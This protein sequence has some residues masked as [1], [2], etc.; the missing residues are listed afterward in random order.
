VRPGPTLIGSLVPRRA[1]LAYRHRFWRATGGIPTS[2]TAAERDE[3]GRLAQDATVLEVG[4][5]Y[6]ASTVTL[7]SVARIVYAIDH[8]RGDPVSGEWDTLGDFMAEIDLHGLRDRVVPLVG[9]SEQLVEVLAEGRFDLVFV[10][11]GKE[12][13]DEVRAQ[14]LEARKLVRPGGVIAFHDY[15]RFAVIDEALRIELGEPLRVIDTLAVFSA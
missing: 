9:R 2:L 15:G 3:L 11:S 12:A 8:H 1:R 13:V 6:G 10:D 5:Q 4:S 7:A 14:A